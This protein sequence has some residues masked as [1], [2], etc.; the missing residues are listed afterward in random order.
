MAN[1]WRMANDLAF[2]TRDPFS[3]QEPGYNS[4]LLTGNVG[5]PI[6]KKSSFFL[7]FQHRNVNLNEIV[8]ASRPRF[9]LQS[10]PIPADVFKSEFENRDYSSHR[11]SAQHQQY[12]D[13]SLRILAARPNQRRDGTVLAG[14]AGV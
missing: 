1:S 4:L 7:D 14:C 9:E 2:D 6:N 13:G 12:S 8:N 3:A 10:G 11:L 5:G